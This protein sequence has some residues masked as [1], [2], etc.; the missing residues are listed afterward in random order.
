VNRSAA[1]RLALALLAG[2]GAAPTPATPRTSTPR[3]APSTHA[4]DVDEGRRPTRAEV[5]TISALLDEAARLRRLRFRGPVTLRVE[6]SAVIGRHIG[7]SADD[8]ELAKSHALYLALGLLPPELDLRAML[9]DVFGEQVVGYYDTRRGRL[10]LREDSLADLMR[11]DGGSV[12]EGRMVVV[13][14]GIHALQDQHFDLGAE[15]DRPHTVDEANAFRALVEGDATLAMVAHQTEQLGASLRE[16][17]ILEAVRR[18]ITAHL[19]RAQSDAT[20]L[21]RAPAILRVPLVAAYADGFDFCAHLFAEGGWRN[22]DRAYARLPESSEEILHP[23]IYVR[24]ERT[25]AIALPSLPM[26]REAGFVTVTED[27]LGELEMRVYFELAL[28]EVEAKRAA[29]GWGGDRLLVVRRAEEAPGA[30]WLT[31]WD[32]FLD[33]EEAAAAARTVREALPPPERPAADVVLL[34]RHVLL[35]RGLPTALHAPVI[36]AVRESLDIPA[37]AP[38]A[39]AAL[40]PAPA[41]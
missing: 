36:A 37:P 6:S 39:A 19:H 38:P 23:E 9:F 34:D 1:W 11:R 33:A 5:R 40:L 20:A 17:H 35:L 28:P 4:E 22:V 13:H 3:P 10:V 18:A 16:P 15:H 2:C 31:H 12:A 8:A 27:T 32:S 21:S 30:V 7:A 25:R 41:P 26:L 24:G 29:A 14:E